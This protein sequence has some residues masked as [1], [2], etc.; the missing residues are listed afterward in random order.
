M[1]KRLWVAL[2]LLLP[3]LTAAELRPPATPLIACDPYFSVW[4]MADHLTDETTKH[5]T[6]TPKASSS[7]IR[8]D[9]ATYRLMGTERRS[10]L[11]AL[12]QTSARGPADAN[13]I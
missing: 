4:S 8:I 1:R 10:S 6:G 7:L 12:P 9:G 2:A 11:P 5:W 13:D 3:G